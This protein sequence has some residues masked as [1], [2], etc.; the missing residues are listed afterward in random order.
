VTDRKADG[1]MAPHPVPPVREADDAQDHSALREDPSDE[2]AMADIANDESFPA[3]DPPSH[4]SVRHG[5][6]AV[7]S[8]Y[9][10]RAEARLTKRTGERSGNA[11]DDTILTGT[12]ASGGKTLGAMRYL[13][14]IS[15]IAIIVIFAAL[16]L[17]YR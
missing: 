3:S 2:Q 17:I 10:E 12:E 1:A 7:S 8:G 9:D 15:L 13:L 5:E 11:G 6:P 14:G 4:A 16:L